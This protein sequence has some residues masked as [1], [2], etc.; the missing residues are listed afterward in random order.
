MADKTDV[1]LNGRTDQLVHTRSVMGAMAVE[2]GV[3]GDISETT[4]RPGIRA[5]AVPRVARKGM[6]GLRKKSERVALEAKRTVAVAEDEEVAKLIVMG[7][8]T[9][10]A[11]HGAGRVEFDALVPTGDGGEVLGATRKGIEIGEGNGVVIAQI[12]ADQSPPRRHQVATRH[13]DGSGFA[14]DISQS[15][16]AIVAAQAELR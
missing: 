13:G 7:I 11:L 6:R 1:F 12:G 4:L 15:N 16:C 8:M 2:T 3:T 14:D 5:D 9:G 10:G